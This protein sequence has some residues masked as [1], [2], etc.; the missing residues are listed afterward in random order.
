MKKN[1]VEIVSLPVYFKR[2][3]V[4]L[5]K[6]QV[7]SAQKKELDAALQ[8]LEEIL[9]ILYGPFGVIC[10]AETPHL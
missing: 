3:Y 9:A 6:A 7:N 1:K 5:Q 10:P 4:F 8:A 2:V